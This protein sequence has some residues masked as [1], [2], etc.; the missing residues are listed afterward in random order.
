MHT[1]LNDT[2]IIYCVQPSYESNYV[3]TTTLLSV[4]S[5]SQRWQ[6]GNQNNEL[7]Y[8]E[9]TKWSHTESHI[10][11]VIHILAISYLEKLQRHKQDIH[12]EADISRKGWK[13]EIMGKKST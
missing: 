2:I 4:L 8:M 1:K 3:E 12:A 13:E 5:R 10:W 6:S 7:R 9:T 11:T